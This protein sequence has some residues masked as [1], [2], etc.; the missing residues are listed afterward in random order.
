MAVRYQ[1]EILTYDQMTK[2]IA[3]FACELQKNGVKKGDV[4]AIISERNQFLP[5]VM[6]ATLQGTI[7][8]LGLY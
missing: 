2:L 4:V 1:D 5:C 6:L 7:P 8:F 3:R